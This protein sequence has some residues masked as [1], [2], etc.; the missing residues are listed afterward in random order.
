MGSHIDVLSCSIYVC[1]GAEICPMPEI[2]E[3]VVHVDLRE[4]ELA[5][6]SWP[7]IA[8]AWA[9]RCSSQLLD[10]TV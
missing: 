5:K 6:K 4:A 2:L 3:Q 10:T 7:E 8:L 9:L 1:V